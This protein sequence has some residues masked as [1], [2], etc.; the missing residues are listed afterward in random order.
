MQYD[1]VPPN[2]E[3]HVR[4]RNPAGTAR[5]GTDTRPA[6]QVLPQPPTESPP[7]VDRATTTVVLQ[8]QPSGVAHATHLDGMPDA[9]SQ[10]KETS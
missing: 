10:L 7:A 4:L 9:N 2:R 1:Q 8:A 6:R 3:R 5:L